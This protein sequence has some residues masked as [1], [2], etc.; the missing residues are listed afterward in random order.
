[1]SAV[2]LLMS[3]SAWAIT[4]LASGQLNRDDVFGDLADEGRPEAGPRG[5]MTVLLLG[6]DS[7]EGL[8]SAER[9][10]LS[11]GQD[12]EGARADTIM[13]AHLNSDRDRVSVVGIPRD[14]WVEIPGHGPNKINASYNLGGPSLTVQTVEATTGV[15]IDHYVEVDFAGF[16][17]VVDAVDG[18]EVC[19]PEAIQDERTN[20]DM[21]AG[22]HQV[23]GAEALSFA[24]TRA[25][26]EGDLD[27]IDR[28]QQVLAALL[29]RALDTQ[30][31]TEPTRLTG[32]L[33]STL[34][35]LTVD[36]NMDTATIRELA[37]QLGTFDLDD[38][39]FAQVPLSDFDFQTPNGDVAVRWADDEAGQ[40]FDQLRS[41]EPLGDEPTT[42]DS[43]D[44]TG[45]AA[46]DLT[47][48][49][50]NGIGT[51][52]LGSQAHDE[53]SQAGFSIPEDAA[54]W[55]NSDVEE[56]MVRHSP[57]H[58]AE[59]EQVRDVIPG[60]TTVSDDTLGDSMQVVLGMNYT[61]TDAEPVADAGAETEEQDE[62]AADGRDQVNVQ[63][64]QDN[65]CD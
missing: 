33:D 57:D 35:S 59:A 43:D 47:M 64:A 23:N 28:Q 45:P 19:V 30:T 25:T 9:S 63:S 3:G 17:D 49:V 5:A 50:Y 40:L 62:P 16:I 55:S 38:V 54:N 34:D 12:E 51:P 10:E 11:V 44:E 27:R 60:S 48:E 20:L 31:L 8:D 24:R 42:T 61:G 39:S 2:V 56:T 46:S 18:I 13:L 4:G 6:S 36:E 37:G 1:M 7:R 52:G 32:F 41:G 26:P 21:A 22:T 15:H 14:S 65:V 58:A 53:L 29:N